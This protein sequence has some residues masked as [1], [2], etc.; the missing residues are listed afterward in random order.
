MHYLLK[1]IHHDLIFKSIKALEIKTSILFNFDFAN[2]TILSCF[3]FFFLTIDLYF[4]V[5]AVIAKS[6]SPIVIL[7]GIPSKEAKVELKDIQ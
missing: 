2:N 5:P 4:L 3:F 1:Q 7:I 6:F